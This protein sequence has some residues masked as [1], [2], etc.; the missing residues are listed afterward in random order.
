MN[1]VLQL[2]LIVGVIVTFTLI[3]IFVASA[4]SGNFDDQKKMMD[5]MLFDSP[6]DL[7]AAADKEAKQEAMRAKKAEKNKEN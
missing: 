2:E 4:K 3:M 7:Q 6:A 5:G 1:E